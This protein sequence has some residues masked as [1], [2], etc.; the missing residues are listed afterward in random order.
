M[1][2][3]KNEIIRNPQVRMMSS[4]DVEAYWT[5]ERMRNAIPLKI[6]VTAEEPDLRAT[7]LAW[8]RT[9]E[10]KLKESTPSENGNLNFDSKEFLL[11]AG[12]DFET[13]RVNNINDYPYQLIG[14]IFMTFNGRDYV[15]SA[16]TIAESAIFTAGHCV[17]SHQEGVWATNILFEAGYS[18]GSFIKRW[19]SN[20]YYSLNGWVNDGD[21]ASD[22][23]VCIMDSPV[24]ST[25]GTL[26]WMASFSPNQGTITSIGYPADNTHNPNFDGKFMWKCVGKYISGSENIKMHNNMTGGCSGGPWIVMHNNKLYANGLNSHGYSNQPNKMYS[27]YFGQGFLNLYEIAETAIV[28]E[29]VLVP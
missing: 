13:T 20:N 12:K 5:E 19:G 11:D 8:E 21:C 24:S 7:T 10:D 16:W 14:K 4:G 29:P 25:T 15:G 22:M 6:P 28:E 1:E 3:N 17:Y 27:P 2:N 9:A 23:A 18:D 26:G